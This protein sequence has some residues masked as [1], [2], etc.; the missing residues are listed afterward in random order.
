MTETALKRTAFYDLHLAAGAKIVPFAGF[1]MPVSYRGIL[2]EHTAVRERVGVFDVSHMGE[3]L[4][5]GPNAL[6]F[7]QKITVND[8]SVLTIGQAQYSAMCRPDG[9]IVD[10]LLV[11][12]RGPEN[13][14]LVINGANI[15][16]DFAWMQQNAI[17]GAT[18]VNASDDYSLLA[19]QGPKSLQALQKLTATDLSAIEYYHFVEGEIAGVPAIISRTGYT[20]E[21]GFE[22]YFSSDRQPSANVWN[23][24][25]EAGA[26]FGIEPTGL[27]ARDTL[28]LEMGY[29]LYGNDITDDTNTIEAGLGWITKLEKGEFNGREALAAVKAAKPSRK[30]VAFQ[31]KER[32]IPRQHYK[33][34]ADGRDVGEVTSGTSSPTLGE[35]IGMGYVESAFAKVG[36][37][38]AVVIRDKHVSATVVKLPFVKKG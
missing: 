38:I 10:D 6:E 11:Y 1:E 33:I 29:C 24:V 15:D 18:L 30:L 31:M 26:E 37:E 17:E 16:K 35:G 21:L 36:T 25:M 20:G 4:V 27:G 28:R 7:V 5:T 2:A 19:V 32:G 22:L 8:A 14:L 23:A 9:G 34:A 3:V 12:Y 13:Y